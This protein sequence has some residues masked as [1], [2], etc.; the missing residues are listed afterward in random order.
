MLTQ[1]TDRAAAWALLDTLPHGEKLAAEVVW[2]IKR[3]GK[4]LQL[5]PVYTPGH[6]LCIG[7]ELTI[8]RSGRQAVRWNVRYVRLATIGSCLPY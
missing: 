3:H 8:T 6:Q 2:S 4:Y 5:L 7:G 1:P